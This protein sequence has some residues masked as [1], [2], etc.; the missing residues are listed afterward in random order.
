MTYEELKST[1]LAFASKAYR[2]GGEK[3]PITVMFECFL[4]IAQSAKQR[5]ISRALGSLNNLSRRTYNLAYKEDKFFNDFG[6]NPEDITG[7]YE[8][9][10]ELNLSVRD[11]YGEDLII[12]RIDTT[13]TSAV[14]DENGKLKAGWSVK[15]VNGIE[16]TYEGA[17]IYTTTDFGD[18]GEE[19]VRLKQ[20][21]TPEML[22]APLKK[23]VNS[24]KENKVT[25]KAKVEEEVTHSAEESPF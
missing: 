6:I 1:N 14:T 23:A 10:V 20:D 2:N 11:L 22:N 25:A 4:P 13:D 12:R 19:D 16:L 9:A 3:A 8:D 24:V 17:L 7:T 21:Q 5:M 18:V 15:S